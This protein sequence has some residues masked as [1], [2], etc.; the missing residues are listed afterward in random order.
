MDKVKDTTS[1]IDVS[2]EELETW[3][4]R[5]VCVLGPSGVGKTALCQS[6][7][8]EHPEIFYILGSTITRQRS[9]SDIA[10]NNYSQVSE[11]T[12]LQMIEED[13]FLH[14]QRTRHG[15]YG[16]E[17]KRLRDAISTQKI[18]LVTFRSTSAG[19]M[20][21]ILPKLMILELRV[22][23]EII[24][25]RIRDRNRLEIKPLS[26]KIETAAKDLVTNEAMFKYWSVKPDGNWHL[27]WNDKNEPPIAKEVVTQAFTIIMKRT[28]TS[29]KIDKLG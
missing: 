6:L 10:S 28:F 27:I 21:I 17:K 23:L 12:F 9:A 26:V 2:Q 16:L 14:W 22:P 1:L 15:L 18:V 11:E 25:A 29:L 13:A 19:V 4:K 8:A 7:T 3:T 20:K 5:L 24:E